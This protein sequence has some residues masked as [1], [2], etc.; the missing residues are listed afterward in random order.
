MLGPK[1][2]HYAQA[3]RPGSESV[4]G[5]PPIALDDSFVLHKSAESG[6]HDDINIKR[7]KPRSADQARCEQVRRHSKHHLDSV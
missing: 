2:P 4:R 5:S 7:S 3:F 6:S 1:I